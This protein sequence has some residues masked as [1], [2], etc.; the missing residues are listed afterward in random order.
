MT[1]TKKTNTKRTKNKVGAAMW[2]AHLD[3]VVRFAA[4]HR[5]FPTELVKR[6]EKRF[7]DPKKNWRVMLSEW[8]AGDKRR[9]EPLSGTGMVLLEES[10][11]LMREW[12]VAE[13]KWAR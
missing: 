4:T 2:R 5:G 11:K 12:E 9:V 8:L 7:Q 10:T 3:P 6:L 1:T 13:A